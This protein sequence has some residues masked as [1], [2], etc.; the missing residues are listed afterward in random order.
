[1][2][3][4]ARAKKANEESSV[5]LRMKMCD[6]FWRVLLAATTGTIQSVGIIELDLFMMSIELYLFLSSMTHD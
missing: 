6:D 2:T 1:M 4:I 3:L 5:T